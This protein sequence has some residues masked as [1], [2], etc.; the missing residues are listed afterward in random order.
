MRKS[1]LIIIG[2][3]FLT[4]WLI[5]GYPL[6][7]SNL[8]IDRIVTI[9]ISLLIAGLIFLIFRI[10]NRLKSRIYK[11]SFFVLLTCI[12]LIYFWIG[13]W[14]FLISYNTGPVWQNTHI[15]TNQKSR[16]VIEQFRE[17]SGS[18]YDYRERLIFYDFGKGN[19]I[20]IEWTKSRMHGVWKVKDIKSDSTYFVNFDNTINLK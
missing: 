5:V 16:Q 2:L 20:S 6:E 1:I 8:K 7:L 4:I 10:I 14:T 3:L 17:T 11:I 15:F 19:K 9:L 13:L 12:S 18:I